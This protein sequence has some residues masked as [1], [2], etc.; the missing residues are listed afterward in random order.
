MKIMGTALVKASNFPT[1]LMGISSVFGGTAAAAA[2]GN[3][4]WLPMILCLFFA[5]TIQIAA[6]LVHRYY[7]NKYELGENDIDGVYN[8]Y[9]RT[10]YSQFLKS[11]ALVM[12]MV[13]AMPGLALMAVSG[14]WTLIF[15]ALILLFIYLVNCKPVHLCHTPIYTFITF[16]VF[17]PIATIGTSLCQSQIHAVHPFSWFDL[18]P[19]CNMS[20]IMGLMAV[21]CH[22]VYNYA[23]YN[24]D[25]GDG[26]RTFTVIYGRHMN[27]MLFF[28]IGLA[29]AL[30]GS[31]AAFV[32]GLSKW[33]VYLIVPV[34]T[35]TVNS[36]V[37]RRLWL[38][39]SAQEVKKLEMITLLNML[40][41]G[42]VS[43]VILATI[44]L[45]NMDTKT[46]F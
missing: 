22:L 38:E 31:Y 18:Q 24:V 13:S 36:Y 33:W 37:A 2:R 43:M 45:D 9:T 35:F 27:V 29:Y 46:Y 11:C 26:R 21:N 28:F 14:W 32:D 4:E 8:T 30:I 6:N 23:S 39:P 10:E 17:G 20:I 5:V 7:D 34:I 19:A 25:L 41:S 16:L 12:F 15:A 1:L 42:F 40:L 44:G 3:V